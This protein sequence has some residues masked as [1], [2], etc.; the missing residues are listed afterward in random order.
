MT[1]SQER[2][3][4][5]SFVGWLLSLPVFFL[6]LGLGLLISVGYCIYYGSVNLLE[7]PSEVEVEGEWLMSLSFI[8][9]VLLSL[10]MVSIQLITYLIVWLGVGSRQAEQWLEEVCT[11]EFPPIES[12]FNLP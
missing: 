4:G 5:L 12:G 8:W 10:W 9:L 3:A 11:D 7:G 2:N 1:K 6:A